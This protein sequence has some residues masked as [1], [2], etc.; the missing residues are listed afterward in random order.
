MHHSERIIISTGEFIVRT[1]IT[2]DDN[3]FR[4]LKYQA[5]ES[6]TSVSQLVEDAVKYQILEDIE[7]IND[8][9]AREGEPSS[10]FSD[11]V[12]SFEKES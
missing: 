6:H 3:T 8:A 5:V 2:I 7:D 9:E 10:P 1:T 11:L 12:A 4:D